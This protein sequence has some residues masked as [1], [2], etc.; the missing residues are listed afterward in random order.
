MKL[1][2]WLDDTLIVQG[3]ELKLDMAFD[4]VLRLFEL[5]K[6]K[7]FTDTEKI[8]QMF[9]MLVINCGDIELSIYDK[10]ELVGFIFDKFI[11]NQEDEEEPEEDDDNQEESS[12]PKKT[13]DLE[14]D[15]DLIFASFL[16][17][18]N[19]DLFEYQGRL[20]W[21]K[22]IALLTGLSERTPFKKVIEI[23][24]CDVPERNKHNAK[25]VDKLLKLKRLHKLDK[26]SVES[27]NQTFDQ[28]GAAFIASAKGG[29]KHG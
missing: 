15:A 25:D 18:Y 11:L 12:T 6:D 14:K 4:N 27:I 21:K 28:L 20:H 19:M 3:V 26:P 9:E 10:S 17:D 22:F 2:D 13:Y 1:T 24:T 7:D 29:G 16:M 5:Q 23:R 8:E